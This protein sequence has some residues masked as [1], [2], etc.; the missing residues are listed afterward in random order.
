MPDIDYRMLK[1]GYRAYNN[2]NVIA[3]ILLFVNA[4]WRCG[5]VE[6]WACGGVVYYM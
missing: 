2:I 3:I 6:V 1:I 5:R 4:V